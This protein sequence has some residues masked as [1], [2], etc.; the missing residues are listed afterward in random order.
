MQIQNLIK[1]TATVVKVTQL[2]KNNIFKYVEESSY[3]S[4][5][6]KYGIV[7]D[8]LNDGDK[9]YIQILSVKKSYSSISV[10][11]KLL[12][13]DSKIHLFPATPEDLEGEYGEVVD[14]L[15]KEIEDAHEK[16]RK[17]QAMIKFLTDSK[18][19]QLADVTPVAFSVEE[20]DVKT[21]S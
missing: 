12:T 11:Y 19:N 14:A 13:E 3:S 4:P 6:F 16:I 20:E 15:N 21:I 5:E 2:A 17:N 7:M 9:A 18:V 1:S 8:I 10:E